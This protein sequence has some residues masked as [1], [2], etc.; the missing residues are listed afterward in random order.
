M[1]RPPEAGGGTARADHVRPCTR[2]GTESRGGRRA[3]PGFKGSNWL[4]AGNQ[5]L[6]AWYCWAQPSTKAVLTVAQLASDWSALYWFR[7]A[8]RVAR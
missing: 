6:T 5:P 7:A 3:R 4:R 2:T 1:V 8:T